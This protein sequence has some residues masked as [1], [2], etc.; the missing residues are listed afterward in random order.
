MSFFGWIGDAKRP[1]VAA[2][3]LG[4]IVPIQSMQFNC[5]YLR[6]NHLM[7]DGET[8]KSE[9]KGDQLR[10][11]CGSIEDNMPFMADLMTDAPNVECGM[12]IYRVAKGS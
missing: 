1:V 8:W 6:R 2:L 4:K 12:Q 10:D 9:F 3:R 7:H 5:I 11:M